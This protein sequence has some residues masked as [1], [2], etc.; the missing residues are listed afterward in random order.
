MPDLV[1]LQEVQQRS[2][3]WIGAQDLV[4]F[5]LLHTQMDH[6]RGKC[7]ILSKFQRSKRKRSKRRRKTGGTTNYVK[8]TLTMD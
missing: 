2:V 3:N 5:S 8:P 1:S 4:M 6:F 7:K